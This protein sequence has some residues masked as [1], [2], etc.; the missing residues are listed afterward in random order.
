MKHSRALFTITVFMLATILS[1]APDTTAQSLQDEEF[2]VGITYRHA[3]SEFKL[4]TNVSQFGLSDPRNSVGPNFGYTHY[5]GGKNRRGNFGIGFDAV[6]TFSPNEDATD[7]GKTAIG[8]FAYKMVYMDNR[9]D[10]KYRLGVKG[11]VGA[12]RET[13][14]NRAFVQ[15]QTVIRSRGANAWTAGGGAFLDI[16][17]N[18]TRLRFSVDAYQ[19]FYLKQSALFPERSDKFNLEGGISLVF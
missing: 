3:D 15:G 11:T 9:P 18:R 13:W 2:T 19:S 7:G 16:G 1:A 10:K 14:R 8:R 4:P 17:K 5:F 12:A 6:V